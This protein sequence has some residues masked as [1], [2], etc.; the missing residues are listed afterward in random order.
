[1]LVAKDRRTGMV[2]ARSVGTKVAADLHAVEKLGE[3]VDVL[4]SI[5]VTIRKDGEPAVM[6]VAAAG[7]NARRAGS[8]TTLETSASGD[9]AG[10]GLAERAVGLVEWHGQ[11]SQ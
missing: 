8:V 11:D 7:R 1:M 4:G 2:F 3:W 9:H 5:Q 6:H 10:N